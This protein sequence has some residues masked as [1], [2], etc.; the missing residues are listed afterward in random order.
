MKLHW[1][2][3]LRRRPVDNGAYV[4]LNLPVKIFEN[5]TGMVDIVF[6]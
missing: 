2:I 1:E 3:N 4:Y 6:S 5:F